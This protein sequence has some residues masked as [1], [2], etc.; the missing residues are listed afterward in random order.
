[1][2]RPRVLGQ[3][4]DGIRI[5]A[6]ASSATRSRRTCAGLRY[7]YFSSIHCSLYVRLNASTARRRS[8]MVSKLRT[9]KRFYGAPSFLG[10]GL[11]ENPMSKEVGGMVG[12]KRV[13]GAGSTPGRPTRG[14]S[15]R[16]S[17]PGP[18]NR[19]GPQGQRRKPGEWSQVAFTA[20]SS[21]SPRPCTSGPGRLRGGFRRGSCR[22]QG[23]PS[24]FWRF[25][26]RL[27]QRC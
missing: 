21:G 1:M 17:R 9:H 20:R 12:S 22:V 8:S 18:Q 7:A 27:C 5:Y 10:H 11:R 16:R 26:S 2:Y 23:C 14:R 19:E 25:R 15:R 24:H 4:F 13:R 3:W 6:A